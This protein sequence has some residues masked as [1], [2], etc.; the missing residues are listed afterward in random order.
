MAQ[1]GFFPPYVNDPNET[2]DQLVFIDDPAQMFEPWEFHQ[3]ILF[4]R[5]VFAILPHLLDLHFVNDLFAMGK[6]KRFSA[7]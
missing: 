6:Y 2:T 3:L 4:D 5:D 1:A 7:D